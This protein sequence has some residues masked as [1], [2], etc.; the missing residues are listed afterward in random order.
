ME[1]TVVGAYKL[2]KLDKALL[3]VL[4][5][6]Y[7]DSDIDS[8]GKEGLFVK[9]PPHSH[10]NP[11]RVMEV[12]DIVIWVMTGNFIEPPKLPK[13]HTTWTPEQG[14]ANEDYHEKRDEA[15]RQITDKFGWC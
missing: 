12:E 4:L 2:G 11:G 3:R 15:F 1:A 13:D 10:G 7:R 8:G 14:E 5:E 9:E 6:P